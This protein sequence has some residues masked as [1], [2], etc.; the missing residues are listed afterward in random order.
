[1]KKLIKYKYFNGR[2]N[3]PRS[4]I[5]AINNDNTGMVKLLISY[6][7]KNNIILDSNEKKI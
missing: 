1:M 3:Q 4:H 2:Y 6:I 5:R 7:N